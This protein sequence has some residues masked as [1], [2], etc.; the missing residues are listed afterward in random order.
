MKVV[1]QHSNRLI[2]ARQRRRAK[3]L[4]E[5]RLKAINNRKKGK[6]T[7]DNKAPRTIGMSHLIV[8]A[9][10]D[11]KM[12]ER[13]DEIEKQ[14]KILLQKMTKI[15]KSKVFSFPQTSGPRSLNLQTRRRKM[16][17]VNHDNRLLLERISNVQ[18][19]YDRKLW[20]KDD[21]RNRH[22]VKNLSKF[23]PDENFLPSSASS[24]M[25][26]SKS[27]TR[28]DK[29]NSKSDVIPKRPATT[30]KNM[31]SNFNKNKLNGRSGGRRIVDKS[32][33]KPHTANSIISTGKDLMVE[34]TP[35]TT[36]TTDTNN[37]NND[38]KKEDQIQTATNTKELPPPPPV[39]TAEQVTVE[40]IF[41]T[42]EPK[43][44]GVISRR[45]FLRSVQLNT[46]VQN[47]LNSNDK[48]KHLTHSKEI[49]AKF[50]EMD[51]NN[52]KEVTIE[53]M[54]SYAQ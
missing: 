26:G 24:I 3:L 36:T 53:E 48:L 7:L 30:N 49:M 43:H 10:R 34:K 42:I 35:V 32:I 27:T 41:N 23:H 14:N 22:I 1:P 39:K 5:K 31:N 29:K 37:V 6:G 54:L 16:L 33:K 13:F 18:P 25:K 19:L 21:K 52:D 9:K 15:M 50:K 51:E 28:N 12:E 20:K 17:L 8:N 45:R 46:K 4:H 11:K 40:A 2:A 38:N 44:N 47:L